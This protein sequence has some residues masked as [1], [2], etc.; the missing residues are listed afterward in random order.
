MEK[1]Q[2]ANECMN[3]TPTCT[4]MRAGSTQARSLSDLADDLAR[5]IHTMPAAARPFAHNLIGMLKNDI[6]TKPAGDHIIQN[7]DVWMRRQTERLAAAIN[8]EDL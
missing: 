5:A 3:E 6:Q 8:A 1:E 2:G 4:E 7:P